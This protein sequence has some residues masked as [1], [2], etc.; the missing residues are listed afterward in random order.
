MMLD[1]KDHKVQ[2]WQMLGLMLLTQLSSLWRILRMGPI[3]CLES[4]CNLSNCRQSLPGDWTW[5]LRYNLV[6]LSNLFS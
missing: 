3:L 4:P 1:F 6:A 5:S 2:G